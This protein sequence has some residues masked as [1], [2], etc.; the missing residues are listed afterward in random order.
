MKNSERT[1]HRYKREKQA[2]PD[3]IGLFAELMFLK[4]S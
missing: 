4:I 2:W 3:I 1:N